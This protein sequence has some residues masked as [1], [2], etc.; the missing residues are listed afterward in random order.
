M[1]SFR[2]I[3]DLALQ[4]SLQ[5]QLDCFGISKCALHNNI[6]LQANHQVDLS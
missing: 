6:L 2:S 5:G 3:Y 1:E 4:G